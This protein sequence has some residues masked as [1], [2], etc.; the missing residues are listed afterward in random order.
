M[1]FI[2]WKVFKLPVVYTADRSKA[3]VPMLFLFRVA[4]VVCIAGRFVFGLALL[5]VYV[6]LLSF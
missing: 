3:V 6:F 4:G 5:F 2:H 1:K